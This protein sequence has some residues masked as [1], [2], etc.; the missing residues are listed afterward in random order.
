M[1]NINKKYSTLLNGLFGQRIFENDGRKVPGVDTDIGTMI[2]GRCH[3]V[4]TTVRQCGQREM[5]TS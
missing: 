1:M 4:E 3:R 2:D 5:L